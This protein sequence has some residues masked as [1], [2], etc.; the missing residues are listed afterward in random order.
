MNPLLGRGFT[1]NIKPYFLRKI[2]VKKIKC[3]LLQFLFGTLRVSLDGYTFRGRNKSTFFASLLSRVGGQ[4]LNGRICSSRG[5]FF[6]IKSKPHFEKLL[7]EKQT[8]FIQDYV[9]LFSKKAGVVY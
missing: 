4:L 5:K 3:H 8:E 2:K 7:I 1:C 9:K 6:S